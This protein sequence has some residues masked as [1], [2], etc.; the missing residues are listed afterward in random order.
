MR[1]TSQTVITK[2]KDKNLYDYACDI[3]EKT[4]LLYNAALFRIRQVFTG[5]DKDEK[6]L[7]PLQKQDCSSSESCRLKRQLAE[8]HL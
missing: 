7:H 5:W 3:T 8:P 2:T 1:M 6:D 4:P